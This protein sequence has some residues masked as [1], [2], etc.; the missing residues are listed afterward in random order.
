MLTRDEIVHYEVRNDDTAWVVMALDR[1]GNHYLIFE[2]DDAIQ[3]YLRAT[4][5]ERKLGVA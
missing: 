5:L 4:A 2:C 1:R 3:A